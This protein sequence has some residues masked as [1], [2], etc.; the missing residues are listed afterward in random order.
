MTNLNIF[1]VKNQYSVK[2]DTNID[3]HCNIVIYNIQ[4]DKNR[5]DQVIYMTKTKIH[6][7]IKTEMTI[8]LHQSYILK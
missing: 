8:N 5:D 1:N 6:A 2:R 3:D 4:K 7:K